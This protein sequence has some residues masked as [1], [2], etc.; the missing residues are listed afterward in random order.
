MKPTQIQDKSENKCTYNNGLNY[1]E[2]TVKRASV[3]IYIKQ[4]PILSSHTFK[5][6]S[7]QTVTNFKRPV[8]VLP[9]GVCLRKFHHTTHYCNMYTAFHGNILST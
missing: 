7:N 8:L 9:I 6:P 5:F 3:V 1:I 2:T 4:P